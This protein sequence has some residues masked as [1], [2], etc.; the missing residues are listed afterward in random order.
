MGGGGVEL[1]DKKGNEFLISLPPS[2]Q[3][4]LII[5][6]LSQKHER[7]EGAYELDVL[8]RVQEVGERRRDELQ[9]LLRGYRG[10]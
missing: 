10:E 8:F 1:V 9:A 7:I 6:C 5:R 2:S 3:S 4:H